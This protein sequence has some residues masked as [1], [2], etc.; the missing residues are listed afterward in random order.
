MAD[1]FIESLTKAAPVVVFSAA[2]PGQGGT[3]H[4]NLQWP[5]YWRNLF[6]RRGFI[7]C[8]PIRPL[9]WCDERVDWVYRQNIYVFLSDEAFQA[10]PELTQ[11]RI[12]PYRH[13]KLTVIEERILRGHATPDSQPVSVLVGALIRKMRRRL[14]PSLPARSKSEPEQRNILS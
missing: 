6:A 7:C 8:D 3:N 1:Q 9:L 13:D 12:D 10:R 11:Y 14:H 4:I 2:I 5:W